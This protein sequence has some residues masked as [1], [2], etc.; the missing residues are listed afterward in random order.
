MITA[1]SGEVLWVWRKRHRLSVVDAAKALGVTRLAYA[2]AEHDRWP[3]TIS[4]DPPITPTTAELLRVCR[5]R[6]GVARDDVAEYLAVCHVT[7]LK[8]EREANERLVNL[9]LS[10][11]GY[12]EK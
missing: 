5:R 4:L 2:E 9:W 11:A 12:A 1:T 8:L 10:D 3:A 6:S 7:Y